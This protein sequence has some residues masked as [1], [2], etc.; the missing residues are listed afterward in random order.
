MFRTS[1]NDKVGVIGTGRAMTKN[2]EPEK[3]RFIGDE[4]SDSVNKKL[5]E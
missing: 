4:Y 2:A 3:Y 1:E 5:K